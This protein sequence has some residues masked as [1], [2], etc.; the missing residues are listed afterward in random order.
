MPKVKISNEK[1]L[2]ST[3][4]TDIIDGVIGLILE[5]WGPKDR[6]PDYAKAMEQI[7]SR[8]IE[9]RI[10]FINV[11]VVSRDLTK[12][13]P[14]LKDRVITINGSIN[15]N[16][17]H[18]NPQDLRLA[19]GREVSNLKEN[20]S[21]ESKGGN[22]FK[23]I[24]IHSPLLSEKDWH[25][26]AT[27]TGNLD[28]YEPTAE[29]EKLES[30]VSVLQQQDSLD[31]PNGSMQPQKSSVTSVTYLR[32]PL[33][34]AW[35]LKNA[36][37]ICEACSSPAPFKK[38]DGHPYLEVH[39]LQP[40]SEGGSDTIENAI[41]VCANCHRRLH[42]GSDKDSVLIKIRSTIARFSKLSNGAS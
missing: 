32:D 40:L 12:A 17:A 30:I 7:L 6:N 25:A 39:H 4:T 8:L 27:M 41:A 31:I 28:I 18:T 35:V 38:S 13:F 1:E 24:L 26:I 10:P 29:Y 37:G 11:Y 19:V 20:S 34:K 3:Y 2:D 22:R 16:L 21:R 5:S 15:L 36:Q 33:V 14:N 23:R 42:F 9:N